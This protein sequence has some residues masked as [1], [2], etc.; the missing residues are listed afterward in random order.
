MYCNDA[1]SLL[2]PN[3]DIESCVPYICSGGVCAA[4][5]LAGAECYT[6]YKCNMSTQLCVPQ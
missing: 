6:G 1:F 5:C 4:H 3:G 2:Y